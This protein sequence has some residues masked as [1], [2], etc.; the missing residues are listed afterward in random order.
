MAEERGLGSPLLAVSGLRVATPTGDIV[1]GVDLEVRRREVV[2]LL[3]ES[4][5]G[6]TTLALA[7]AGLLRGGRKVVDGSIT[8]N[9]S[10][11]V[12]NALDRT[13]LVRG[14]EIGFVPQDPFS[15]LDPLRRIGPQVARSLL[16]HKR[17]TRARARAKVM[18][19]L[20]AM[21]MPDP[22]KIV[23]KYPHEL[24]GGQ[25]QRAVIASALIC[26]PSLVIADEP[27]S[28]L[29]VIV[30]AQVLDKFL[31]LTG[32]LGASVLLVSHDL[33][34][35]A[36]TSDRVTAMYAGRVVE[37]GRVRE[38]LRSPRH[39]YVSALLASLP[40]LA[41]DRLRRLPSIGGQPPQI[42]G[43]LSPCA[44]A[45]RCRYADDLCWNVQPTYRWPAEAGFACHHPLANVEPVG[46]ERVEEQAI[47]R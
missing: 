18:E 45:P 6:K 27:T 34:I 16:V 12:T 8:F 3:G 26:E 4:G 29:D 47:E 42:P 36:E 28:A 25:R 13:A 15:A 38:L 32:E 23:A 39:P 7:I 21:G 10:A 9:G 33:G 5:C 40:S 11:L 17:A 35:L 31:R 20:D 46:D 44:F 19:M 41:G 14:V 1:R 24:S 37:F 30:Q 22:D 2:G 43:P